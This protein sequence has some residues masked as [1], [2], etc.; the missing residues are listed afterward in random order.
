[1][2]WLGKKDFTSFA[3]EFP[4]KERVGRM[5]CRVAEAFFEFVFETVPRTHKDEIVHVEEDDGDIVRAEI[6]ARIAH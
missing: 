5:A 3:F 6:Q 4:A 1:M 2:F